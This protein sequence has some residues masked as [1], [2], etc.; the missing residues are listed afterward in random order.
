MND[1]VAKYRA[2]QY[3]VA[4]PIFTEAIELR[5]VSEYYCCRSNCLIMLRDYKSAFEDS[6]VAIGL[7]NM[8]KKG[9]KCNA[10]CYLAL[11]DISRAKE[12]IEKFIKIVSSNKDTERL[13]EKYKR[14]QLSR[15]N[16]IECF[17]RQEFQHCGMHLHWIFCPSSNF[18][19]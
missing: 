7:D 16:A 19:L 2:E 5:P 14:L 3:T 13:K 9:F 10:K 1:G 4:L 17:E 18:S 8:S 6:R 11:G 12:A 15:E